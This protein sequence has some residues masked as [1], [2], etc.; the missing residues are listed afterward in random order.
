M[1]RKQLYVNEIFEAR[2]IYEILSQSRNIIPW[3][4]GLCELK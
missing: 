1:E 3:N 4:F 2:V